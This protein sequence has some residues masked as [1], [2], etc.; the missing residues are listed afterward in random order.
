M[1]RIFG[2]LLLLAAMLQLNPAHAA[3]EDGYDLWL[4]YRLLSPT[5]QAR[6]KTHATAIVAP[7]A[8]S[9][10]TEAALGELQRGLAGMLGTPPPLAAKLRDGALVLATP[11]SLKALPSAPGWQIGNRSPWSWSAASR[12]S[13]AA[14]SQ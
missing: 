11:A 2:L 5:E 4:R 9:A 1:T 10:T 7:A 14:A 3:V 12:P 6:L 13:C 8:R